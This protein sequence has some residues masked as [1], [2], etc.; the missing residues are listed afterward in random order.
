MTSCEKL[1]TSGSPLTAPRQV[2]LHFP[3]APKTSEVYDSYW[4]FACRRQDVYFARLRGS[5][6]PWT[7]DAVIAEHRFTNVYRATD[8]VSQH[9]IHDVI[10][11][12]KERSSRSVFLR[13]LIFKL[14]NKWA[15]WE[16]IKQLVGDLDESTFQIKRIS[17]ALDKAMAK[18]QRLYSAAY[19]MP[20]ARQF[21]DGRKHL[22]HLK[23]VEKMLD[24]E[25]PSRLQ[26][27]GSLKGVYELLLSYGGLGPFLA[28]QYAIDLNYSPLLDFNESDYV[29]AGPGALDG[30]KKCF[31]D[32]AGRSPEDLIRWMCEAQ[33]REFAQRGLEFK[34]LFGRPLQL[35]DCQNV[36]CEVD[37]YARVRH[38]NVL[39]K[40]GRTRIKQGYSAR[41]FNPIPRV[42][43]PPKWGLNDAVT[44]FYKG[45]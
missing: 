31:V 1:R 17:Q 29:V 28:F 35:I 25:L 8:R 10:Y 12:G 38:P 4:N 6:P 40:S 41:A 39:G 19:I 22:G 32:T 42:Q 26:D 14:F 36:F 44:N 27:A 37:K 33:S 15:T 43:L 18:G 16:L 20:T 24:D 7:N 5:L 3:R 2:S 11:D 34:S 30:I 23:L 9:L 21:G 45:L 13:V